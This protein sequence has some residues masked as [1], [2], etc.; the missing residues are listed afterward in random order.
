[1]VL[2]VAYNLSFSR[3]WNSCERMRIMGKNL[4]GK[5]LG[6]GLSQRPDGRYMG[7]AQVGGGEVDCSVRLE[8][9]GIEKESCQSGG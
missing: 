6:K 4:N 9:E 2:G 1:M 8:T 5:E 7:R 3:I